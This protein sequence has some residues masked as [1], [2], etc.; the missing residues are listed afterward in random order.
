MKLT[1]VGCGDA[2]G[3]GGRLQTCYLAEWARGRFLIDCGAS[4]LIGFNRL[5]LDP[6]SI[7]TVFISHLH[8]DHYSGLVW[9]MIHARHVAKRTAPLTIVGP[10]GIEARF[11]AAAEALFPGS[12][13]VDRRYRLTFLELM[14]ETPLEAGGVGVKA[15]EV[16]HPSGAPAYALRFQVEDKV[17][18]FTGDTEW[19]EN[20]VRAGRNADL[21]IMECYQFEGAP[22]FHMSWGKIAAELD[23]IAPERVLLTHM[24]D[25][26]LARRSEVDDPRVVL[27]EDGL[28]V[29]I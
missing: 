21:Y 26:M 17:L 19:V 11:Q 7:E 5:G 8:G 24:A 29:E 9:W 12:A 28:V 1:V 4:T 15:F 18:A 25:P 27:A 10:P 13:G 2:F 23:R 16:S 3:S 20:V 14:P 22:R 6:N